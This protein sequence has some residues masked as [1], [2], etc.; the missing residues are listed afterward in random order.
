MAL[1]AGILGLAAVVLLQRV[2]T[3]LVMLPQ[4]HEVEASHFPFATLLFWVLMGSI[5]AGVVEETSFRGYMQGPIERRHGPVIAILVTGSL[6]GFAHFTHPEVGII[7][8]PY[9]LA[10]AAVY[11]TLAYLTNSIF[12]SMVLHAGGNILSALALFGQGR[13]EWQASS[14]RTRLIWE[15]GPDASFWLGVVAFLVV[16]GIAVG[17]YTALARVAQKG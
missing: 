11:G 15:S 4:Q 5:V 10:V 3:R 17:A 6:F 1:I 8:M 9:Y 12:P 14:G 2:M 16:G 13:S 7:L